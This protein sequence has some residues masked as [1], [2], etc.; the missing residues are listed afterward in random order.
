MGQTIGEKKCCDLYLELVQSNEAKN[1]TEKVATLTSWPLQRSAGGLQAT[2][3]DFQ[4]T[5]QAAARVDLR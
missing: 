3:Q 2:L 5:L 4:P 1:C